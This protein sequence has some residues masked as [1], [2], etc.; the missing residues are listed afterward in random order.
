M[1]NSPLTSHLHSYK[2]SFLTSNDKMIDSRWNLVHSNYISVLRS[3]QE[4]GHVG[5]AGIQTTG[6]LA[7]FV[8]GVWLGSITRLLSLGSFSA[9][10]AVLI[11]SGCWC[12]KVP[13]THG[14]GR[15]NIPTRAAPLPLT[16]AVFSLFPRHCPHNGPCH[17]A[18]EWQMLQ[19]TESTEVETDW[20]YFI[21]WS[22]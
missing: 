16:W 1:S 18:Y 17:N 7:S 9:S 15:R 6:T 20:G 21:L 10:W 19:I 8:E 13:Q 4:G 14:K 12:N 11:H 3:R 5:Q 2:S 22:F